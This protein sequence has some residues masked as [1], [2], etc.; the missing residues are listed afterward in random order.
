MDT[1][2]KIDLRK[3]GELQLRELEAGSDV[4]LK[5]SKIRVL[6][7]TV[8]IENEENI[9]LVSE[10]AKAGYANGFSDPE[11]IKTLPAFQLPF[12]SK[13]KKYNS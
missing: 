8:N 13:N 2:V 3:L 11:F 6:A 7:T 1:L 5:G 9:E 12:L 10:K 4:F